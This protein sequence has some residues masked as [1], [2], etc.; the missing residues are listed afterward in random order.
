MDATG[1]AVGAATFTEEAV[2]AL[3]ITLHVEGL[4]PGDH[5]IHIHAVGLCEPDGEQPF[6]S[7]GPHYNPTGGAH[8]GPPDSVELEQEGGNPTVH[9]GDLGNLTVGAD[10]VGELEISTTRFTMS[11]GSRSVFDADG[12]A[13]VIH[14]APD[15]LASQ[16]SGASGGRVACGVVAPPTDPE[17]PIPSTPDVVTVEANVLTPEQV[18]FSPT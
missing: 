12:S 14:A 18:P 11:S 9:G 7:A 17:A 1:S 3:S 8:N 13:I 5:G 2:P 6:V 4:A 15:D 10:G 16:P